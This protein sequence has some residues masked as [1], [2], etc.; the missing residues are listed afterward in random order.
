MPAKRHHFLPQFYLRGFLKHNRS[1]LNVI[2]LDN[3]D[4][5]KTDTKNIG[6]E[7]DWNRVCD[8]RSTAEEYFAEIDGA[9]SQILKK[10]VQR[11][12]LP[13]EE[14]D[15]VLL[16]YFVA[17]LSVHNPIIRN[18][19]RKFQ[20]DIFNHL[21]R[22]WTSS[23]GVYYE[24]VESQDTDKLIPY[25]HMK[26]FVEEG[27]YEINFDHGY[28]LKHEA[29]F[30]Q[31]TL[32]PMLY[33]LNWSLVIAKDPTE[34]LVCSDRPVFMNPTFSQLP[35]ETEFIPDFSLTLPL[36]KQMCLYGDRLGI[37]PEIYNVYKEKR[38][39]AS[40]LSVPFLNSRTTYGAQRHIYAGDLNWEIGT[41]TG[42]KRDANSLIGKKIR[43]VID[44]W[45]N[46]YHSDHNFLKDLTLDTIRS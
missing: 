1:Q 17:R 24:K 18:V 14:D 30:I 33:N 21:G 44:A 46:A 28:F 27:A 35:G 10:I 12:T 3:G 29:K 19:L 16:L 7:T 25:E 23:P 5:F 45:Y 34:S 37:L 20:T 26:R 39:D 6:C 15:R 43:G 2:K 13:T 36:N 11:E 22:W 38:A 8:D 32:I 42:G 40:M 31:E 4:F 41:A 9:T